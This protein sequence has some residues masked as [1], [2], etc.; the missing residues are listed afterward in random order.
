MNELNDLH[1]FNLLTPKP[2]NFQSRY[3]FWN[4]TRLWRMTF[5]VRNENKTCLN[6][7]VHFESL[8]FNHFWPSPFKT[9]WT[10][11]GQSKYFIPAL[12]SNESPSH[13]RIKSLTIPFL[14]N[15]VLV[16]IVWWKI[17][18]KIIK[19]LL[20]WS[21][22]SNCSGAVTTTCGRKLM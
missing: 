3:A 19:L 17:Y 13:G 12:T 6:E 20:W 4:A 18:W 22:I 9:Q 10:N 21:D 2:N 11:N 15:V 16:S 1:V 5:C 14:V 7:L 8:G